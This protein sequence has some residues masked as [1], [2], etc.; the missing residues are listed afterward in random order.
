MQCVA[1]S[2]DLGK[3]SFVHGRLDTSWY[4]VQIPHV[5]HSAIMCVVMCMLLQTPWDTTLTV[6]WISF[7][8]PKSAQDMQFTVGDMWGW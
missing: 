2:L 3:F 1:L 7:I 6:Q 5:V 8:V 4:T